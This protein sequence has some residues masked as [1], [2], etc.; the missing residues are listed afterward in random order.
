MIWT[1]FELIL[2]TNVSNSIPKGE[3]VSTKACF[4]FKAVACP[5]ERVKI[6]GPEPDIPDPK[7]PA[8]K[9]AF[10]ISLKCGIKIERSGSIITSTN[11]R[12][13]RS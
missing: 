2:E 8:D 4:T 10:F 1:P 13:I 6:E 9:A 12:E 7:A 5:S 11:E 3:N